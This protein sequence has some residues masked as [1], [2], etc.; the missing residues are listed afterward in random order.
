MPHRL[1]IKAVHPPRK[2]VTGATRVPREAHKKNETHPNPPC[3][4]REYVFGVKVI[5]SIEK[6]SREFS[7]KQHRKQFKLLSEAINS[8]ENFSLPMIPLALRIVLFLT[9]SE[10]ST[11]RI[12]NTPSLNR[13]GWGGSPPWHPCG[14]RSTLVE[15]LQTQCLKAMWHPCTLNSKNSYITD[16]CWY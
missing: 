14:T 11:Q 1:C 5:V 7:T 16:L 12:I 3:L 9:R 6:F 10:R 2:G 4:G 13:E 15:R 8:L